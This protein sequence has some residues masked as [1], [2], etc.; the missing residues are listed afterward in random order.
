MEPDYKVYN[1]FKRKF[2]KQVQDFGEA[3]MKEELLK[4]EQANDF[5]SEKCGFKVAKNKNLSGPNK[6]WGSADLV[7]YKVFIF[8]FSPAYKIFHRSIKQKIRPVS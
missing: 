8:S 3:R 2:L 6:W 1:F 4:V 7:G 5:V